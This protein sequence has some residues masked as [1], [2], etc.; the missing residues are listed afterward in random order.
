MTRCR[1]S[2]SGVAS[3]RSLGSRQRI[4]DRADSSARRGRG[5]RRRRRRRDRTASKRSAQR[6]ANAQPAAAGRAPARCPGIARQARAGRAAG[7]RREQAARVGM[8]RRREQ[9]ARPAPASTMRPAYITA[10]RSAI[11]ATTPRSC[12]M[13]SSDRWNCAPHLAQQIENLRLHRDVERRRR[14]VGDD[15][16]RARRRARARSSRAAAGRRS[17]DADTRARAAPDRACARRRAARPRGAV[18]AAPRA[19]PCTRER[20]LDL[21]ADRVDRIERDHRLLEDEADAPAADAAHRRFVEVEQVLRR[22]ARSRPPAMRPGGMTSRMIDSAVTD[23]PLPD[24][25]TR[26]SVSP[27]P[28]A[29]DTSSTAAASRPPAERGTPCAGARPRAAARQAWMLTVLAEDAPQ[30]VGDLAERRARL[31]GAR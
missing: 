4:A 7:N 9:I 21:I 10:T 11:S 19:R 1:T 14:L 24:S 2:R 22:R 20:L 12:V 31:D 8:R 17:A 27:R 5:R 16:A 3:S 13:S 30:R 23:L 26:P 25:P 29:N 6:G 18:A 28:I 15:A